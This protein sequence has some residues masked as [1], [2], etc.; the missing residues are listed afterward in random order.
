MM[1]VESQIAQPPTT[2]KRPAGLVEAATP[3]ES[4]AT[5]PMEMQLHPLHAHRTLTETA[6]QLWTRWLTEQLPGDAYDRVIG[7]W[8][9][10]QGGW[11]ALF[12]TLQENNSQR[13][14]AWCLHVARSAPPQLGPQPIRLLN[15]LT[16]QIRKL[17]REELIEV[18]EVKSGRDGEG[19]DDISTSLSHRRLRRESGTAVFENV[20]AQLRAI[21]RALA[22]QQRD[23]AAAF[24]NDLIEY[25]LDH[26][27][28]RYLIKSL[29]NLAARARRQ[30]EVGFA[31]QCID[32]AVRHAPCNHVILNGQAEVL[33]AQGRL[34]EALA[35]YERVIAEAPGNV[36]S[37]SGRAEVLK[38]QGRL[39]ES[40]AA[41][42]EI[43][44][45]FPNNH[46]AHNG[47]AA[48]LRAQGRLGESLAAYDQIVTE[49]PSNVVA[50][51]GRAEVLKDQG[52][53]AEACLAYEQNIIEFPDDISAR[54]GRAEVLKAQGR[55]DEAL[56]AYEQTLTEFPSDLATFRG[57]AGVMN[58]QRK[59][60]RPSAI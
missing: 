15:R 17:L 36:I 13:F 45:L 27:G 54:N 52:R 38:A 10:A 7:E 3:S 30:G 16:E 8:F 18:G 42:D 29:S 57:H 56:A 40:L 23:R 50:R 25:H 47:R 51:N 44:V 20:Q 39:A 59:R 12:T 37:L 55:L 2:P 28:P 26:G 46:V 34:A 22:S 49:F 41:Y 31:Q 21:L 9:A 48:V 11:D 6:W 1:N 14:A 53:R 60:S 33:K 32:L 4:S 35:V 24:L 58:A 5:P 19:F 43:L